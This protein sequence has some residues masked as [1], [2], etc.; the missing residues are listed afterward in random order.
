VLSDATG[1][2]ARAGTV[3]WA[4][5]VAGGA[6]ARFGHPKQFALLAGRPVVERSVT[7]CR[8]VAAGVV[9]VLPEGRLEQGYGADIVVAGGSSRSE[10][11]RHG[12]A[13]VPFD[14]GIVVVHDAARPLAGPAL[15]ASVLAAL[16]HG[17]SV[18]GAVCGIP[19]PDTLKRVDLIAGTVSGTVDR[20][21]VIAVQTPQAFRA[22]VLRRAHAA[23]VDA[24]DDAA[25]VEALGTTVRVVPGDPRNIKLTTPADLVYAEHLLGG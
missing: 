22:D 17:P 23:G 11:V 2:L 9:L 13:E 10:S 20:S 16:E 18:G 8:S 4:V 14:A 5:V 6:G 25:L 24:T 19:V 7:A 21:D 1:P 12:L 15:F 3:V